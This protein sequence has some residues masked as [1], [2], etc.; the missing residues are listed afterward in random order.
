MAV[1]TGEAAIGTLGGALLGYLGARLQGK[2]QRA[3]QREQHREAERSHRQGVYHQ[4]LDHMYALARLE[5]GDAMSHEEY[6]KWRFAFVHLTNGVRLFGLPETRA[7]VEDLV[8]VYAQFDVAVDLSADTEEGFSGLLLHAWEGVAER[9][10]RGAL[11]LEDA[12]RR[13]VTASF[14]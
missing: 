12:L 1:T 9:W 2:T 14:D 8:R 5:I 6:R 7:A 11:A 13:D 10:H 3:Q 4:L